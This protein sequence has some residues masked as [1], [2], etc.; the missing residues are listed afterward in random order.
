MG[1]SHDRVLCSGAR[2]SAG[3]LDF[4]G[5]LELRLKRLQP[6]MLSDY[7]TPFAQNDGPV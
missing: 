2:L 5:T 4:A 3:E 1:L 6:K 7:G